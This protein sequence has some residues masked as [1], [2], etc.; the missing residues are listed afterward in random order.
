VREQEIATDLYQRWW[1]NGEID[2]SEMMNELG[3]YASTDN[4]DTKRTFNLV[5]AMANPS[6]SV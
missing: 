5:G 1:L 3:G 4:I 2:Y 6:N